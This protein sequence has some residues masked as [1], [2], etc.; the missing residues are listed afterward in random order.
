MLKSMK[1]HW[2]AFFLVGTIAAVALAA[3]YTRFTYL[4]I[5]ND[6][7]VDNT[8]TFTGT[9]THN[10]TANF[11]GATVMAAPSVTGAL[12]LY[13]RTIAQLNALAPGT[14]GQIVFCSNCAQSGICVSSGVV[15]GAWVV[16]TSTATVPAYTSIHCQ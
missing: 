7:L 16:P 2:L 3:A 4:E 1:N 6:L 13:S 5:K 10:G 14:T 11:N 15:A 8:S 12:T 9:E